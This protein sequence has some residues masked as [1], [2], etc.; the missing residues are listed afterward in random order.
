MGANRDDHSGE[1]PHFR[2]TGKVANERRSEDH[3]RW[4]SVSKDLEKH[5]DGIWPNPSATTEPSSNCPTTGPNGEASSGGTT[6]EPRR[7]ATRLHHVKPP[8]HPP[9]TS[10]PPSQTEAP[11][12]KTSP[13]IA[14]K[15][16][17]QSKT[18]KRLLDKRLIAKAE[19]EQGLDKPRETPES[20]S[21]GE[22]SHQPPRKS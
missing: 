7:D 21:K 1:K 15:R 6:D 8:R 10:S 22:K 16:R 9:E 19:E 20:T 3:R 14:T 2:Q 5:A 12:P 17:G 18:K 4:R 11:K 13:P